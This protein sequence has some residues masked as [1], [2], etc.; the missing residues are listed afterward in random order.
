MTELY[1]VRGVHEG[2]IGR[3]ERDLRE[4]RNRNTELSREVRGRE[5]QRQEDSKRIRSLEDQLAQQRQRGDQLQTQ[6]QRTAGPDGNSSGSGV[7]NNTSRGGSNGTGV[8]PQEGASRTTSAPLAGSNRVEEA[9]TAIRTQLASTLEAPGD[10]IAS[11][12]AAGRSQGRGTGQATSRRDQ[13]AEAD[14]TQSLLQ[15]TSELQLETEQRRE[16]SRAHQTEAE[17]HEATEE[18]AFLQAR[19]QQERSDRRGTKR[20]FGCT[21]L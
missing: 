21:V 13:P 16:Q 1:R 3:V 17:P 18:A 9:I 4:A 10:L 6:L 11:C 8:E 14:P 19:Q 12:E 2:E 15:R 7:G 20:K 5:Q